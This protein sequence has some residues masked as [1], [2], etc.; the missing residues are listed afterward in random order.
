MLKNAI[1][2]VRNPA[3]ESFKVFILLGKKKSQTL[4]QN[5]LFICSPYRAF[6]G[7]ALVAACLHLKK[8]VLFTAV[9][10]VNN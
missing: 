7:F 6:H 9:G 10:R 4:P 2:P 8:R 3:P 5:V 1:P